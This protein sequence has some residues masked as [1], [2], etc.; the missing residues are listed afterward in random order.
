MKITHVV[1]LL[2]VVT[3]VGCSSVKMKHF[4]D[5]ESVSKDKI[6]PT[7]ISYFSKNKKYSC[8]IYILRSIYPDTAFTLM[9]EVIEGIDTGFPVSRI[10][11]AHF[12]NGSKKRMISADTCSDAKCFGS[13]TMNFA[14]AADFTYLVQKELEKGNKNNTAFTNAMKKK[15]LF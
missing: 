11:V 5:W 12:L 9:T 6:A 1:V 13:C 3:I 15:K 2:C 10:F 7:S 8:E 14:Q 4:K